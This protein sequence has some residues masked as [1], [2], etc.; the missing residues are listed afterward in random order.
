MLNRINI[1][2]LFQIIIEISISVLLII[3]LISGRIHLLIHPKFDIILW[4]SS[5]VLLLMAI[6]SIKRLK[7]ARHMNIITKYTVLVIPIFLVIT[8]P[9]ASLKEDSSLTYSNITDNKLTTTPPLLKKIQNENN[10]RRLYKEDFGRDYINITDDRY[11]KWYYDMTF[12][13]EKFDGSKFKFL[14]RVFKPKKDE[15]FI[16]FGRYGMICCMADMQPCGFVYNGKNYKN[17][18][19]GQW[20]YITGK[21]RENNRYTFNYEKMPLI[22]DVTFEKANKPLDEYVYIGN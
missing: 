6:F 16:V 21:I 15:G 7:M 22:Y 10:L 13:W 20:Y 14:G 8:T 3:G 11:L 4:M 9:V 18:E 5:I 19:D 17:F 2:V 12:S 1:E